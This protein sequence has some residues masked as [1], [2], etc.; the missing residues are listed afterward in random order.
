MS[1]V[2]KRSSVFA[3]YVLTSFIRMILMNC[4]PQATYICC[5][6]VHFACAKCFLIDLMYLPPASFQWLMC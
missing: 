3:V 4:I 1:C 6:L 2:Y 5:F